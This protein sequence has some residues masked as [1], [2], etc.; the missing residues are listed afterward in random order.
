MKIIILLSILTLLNCAYPGKILYLFILA[1]HI[2]GYYLTEN[3]IDKIVKQFPILSRKKTTDI[4]FKVD[5]MT[6]TK[7]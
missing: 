6:N 3:N 5:K 1:S 7:N 2:Y 4:F